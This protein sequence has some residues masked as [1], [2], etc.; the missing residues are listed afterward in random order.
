MRWLRCVPKTVLN[1]EW[2][3]KNLSSIGSFFEAQDPEILIQDPNVCEDTHYI[4]LYKQV[5]I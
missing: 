1:P 4:S 5:I 3:K 2:I